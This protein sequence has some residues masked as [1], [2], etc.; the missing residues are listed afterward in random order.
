MTEMCGRI[1]KIVCLNKFDESSFLEMLSIKDRG[2]VYEMEREFNIPIS[3]SDEK[4]EEMAHNAYVSGLG[5]R[6][7]KNVIREYIDE[8]MW[9]DCHAKALDIV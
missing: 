7:M 2:P 9:E 1:E 6:G 3:I 8:L 4:K 5:I